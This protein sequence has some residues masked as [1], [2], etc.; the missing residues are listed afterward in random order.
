MRL[1]TQANKLVV[2]LMKCTP[3]YIRCIKPNETK[4]AKDWEDSRL[5]TCIKHSN[6][7]CF[8]S[9]KMGVA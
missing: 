8:Y 3:H 7:V 5:D 6:Y 4:K 2:A 1:Q 9:L